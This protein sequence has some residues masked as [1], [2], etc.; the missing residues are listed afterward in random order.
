MGW[1]MSGSGAYTAG[2]RPLLTESAVSLPAGTIEAEI[3]VEFTRD[4]D[5]PFSTSST[6]FNRDLWKVPTIGLSIGIDKRTEL[7]LNYDVLY[8]DEEAPGVGKKF[9]SGDLKIFTKI[10]IL[11]DIDKHPALGLRLGVKL[12]NAN[13]IVRL[14][15]NE[16]DFLSA[17][18]VTK[19]YEGVT[20]HSNVGFAILGNPNQ[21]TQQDDLLLFG[22]A[23]IVPATR[24]IHLVMEIA[25]QTLSRRNNNVSSM[26]LGCQI[27]IGDI[28]LDLGGG[29]RLTNQAADWD[30]LGGLTWRMKLR[31]R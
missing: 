18:L 9:G 20:F 12:P 27:Q 8:L 13:D 21:L 17:L 14:G 1:M 25:G 7:Q 5:F 11:E 24:S 3:G 19:F 31:W 4:Q 22:F 29:L 6:G 23:S 28:H 15:T 2:Q 30:V 16:T 10:Q 26:R